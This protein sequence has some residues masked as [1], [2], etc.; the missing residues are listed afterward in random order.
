MCLCVA[1]LIFGS[2][3]SLGG[4]ASS[5][6][7]DYKNLKEQ[8]GRYAYYKDGE[9]VS[10]TVI[11]VSDIQGD[12]NWSAVKNDS[13]DAAMIRLGRRGYTEG[14]IYLDSHFYQNIVQAQAENLPCGV[15][16]FSQAITEAEAE[17]EANFV[18]EHLKGIN[19][20]LPI[21]F[22]HEPIEG[23]N[24]R[25]N[26]LSQDEVTAITKAFCQKIKDA[27]YTPMIYGN[28]NDLQRIDTDQFKDIYLWYAEYECNKPSTKLNFAMWQYSSTSLVAG[29]STK[30]DLSILFEPL[31]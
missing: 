9:Q 8:N 31:S 6:P 27:G 25:A 13:V 5:D 16:F 22:D 3:F 18:I 2:A 24:G 15:Y 30:A 20:S 26:N 21:T 11:D 14:S 23:E 29:V 1:C 4:C 28:S 10:K 12:V 7:Y 17:E 19:L